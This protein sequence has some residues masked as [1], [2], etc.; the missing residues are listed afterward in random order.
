[1]AGRRISGSR[2]PPLR[3]VAL[4]HTQSLKGPAVK[5]PMK[6]PTNS[7]RLVSPTCSA[8]QLY[9]G[10]AKTCD[11]VRLMMSR[12]LQL[13]LTAKEANRTMGKANR[14]QG[15][16]SSV[17]MS[18]HVTGVVWKAF[19]WPRVGLP[20]P[21]SDCG[22]GLGPVVGLRVMSSSCTSD[23]LAQ[24]PFALWPAAV[25]PR[26]QMV[27]G[28]PKTIMASESTVIP[29]HSQK[30]LGQPVC[31]A[32]EPDTTGAIW[33]RRLWSARYVEPGGV[34]LAAVLE[35]EQVSRDGGLDRLGWAGAETVE[36]GGRLERGQNGWL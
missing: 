15:V 20:L 25:L 10:A 18:R 28:K 17:Q 24:S 21:T 16:Q 3:A 33:S 34:P 13:Q 11:C 4:A 1:M 5:R 7:G 26:C 22:G 12:P 32:M 14:R 9:G 31:W 23:A 30:K 35:E 29:E 27:S 36:A 2:T 6:V 8:V 19:H